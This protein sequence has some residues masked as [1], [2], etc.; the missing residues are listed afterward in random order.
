MHNKQYKAACLIL[1]QRES[2]K[3]K[4]NT[5]Q[6]LLWS[7]ETFKQKSACW[8]QGEI[9]ISTDDAELSIALKGA[10]YEVLFFEESFSEPEGL[11]QGSLASLTTLREDGAHFVLID[12]LSANSLHDHIVHG[13]QKNHEFPD[14]V[15]VS[16][17]EAR[18]HPCQFSR[19][20]KHHGA[21][22]INLLDEKYLDSYGLVS[23]GGIASHPCKLPLPFDEVSD[24]F[25]AAWC[26]QSLV[27]LSPKSLSVE[28]FLKGD[29]SVAVVVEKDGMS[30]LIFP[31][32]YFDGVNDD[33][34][35]L[36]C[37]MY[38]INGPRLYWVEGPDGLQLVSKGSSEESK[39]FIGLT[40][41]QGVDEVIPLH[42]LSQIVLR[43]KLEGA[44]TP[45][46]VLSEV[47]EGQYDLSMDYQSDMQLWSVQQGMKFN[48]AN[49]EQITG[50]QGFPDCRQVFP[51]FAIGK[52]SN[53]RMFKTLLFEKRV[54]GIDIGVE[55]DFD[56]NDQE[57]ED[58][59]RQAIG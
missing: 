50:R 37:S 25:G 57:Y 22:F 20:F 48:T 35:V 59:Q 10:G 23:G 17:G 18:D 38:A 47:S 55:P 46:M 41:N 56:H 6:Q 53:L 24:A 8:R 30:R 29:E 15:F 42:A 21:G 1:L 33:L 4:A 2:W 26:A 14:D 45:F 19:Y 51:S 32:E 28:A 7:L 58:S 31:P 5:I 11:P 12:F 13:L 27:E 54:R 52:V 34:K 36:G 39:A 9:I 49:G 43:R 44:G 16:I 40:G 3:A